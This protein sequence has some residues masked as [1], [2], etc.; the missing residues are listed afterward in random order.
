MNIL[1]SY[2]KLKRYFVR[3]GFH[4][5]V[6]NR[7]KS[8]K[9]WPGPSP[10]PLLGNLY[11]FAFGPAEG[12]LALGLKFVEEYGPK[13]RFFLGPFKPFLIVADGKLLKF[14]L[15]CSKFTRKP[16]DYETFRNWLGLGLF[17]NEG[18]DWKRRRRM[19]APSF[20]NSALHNYFETFERVGDIF[21]RK[22]EPEVG[23]ESYDIM[24]LSSLLTLDI[25]YESALGESLNAQGNINMEYVKCIETVCRIISS[26]FKSPLPYFLSP[27]TPNY[28][29]EKK[30]IKVL[31]K[32]TNEIIDR[33]RKEA[34]LDIDQYNDGSTK[35]MAFLDLLLGSTVDGRP[36]TR[37]EL[38]DEI[39]TFIFAVSS[40]SKMV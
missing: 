27:L 35:C 11:E 22:L 33:R 24:P 28:W 13:F 8:L 25:I 36:L 21:I 16:V 1:T 39:E 12:H 5:Y 30:A 9:K 15:S 31:H 32:R 18:S 26:R 40:I 14:I 3:V 37:D 19:L 6:K 29:R 10:N 20:H 17:T 38:R 34:V 23:K 2:A 7:C 4:Y